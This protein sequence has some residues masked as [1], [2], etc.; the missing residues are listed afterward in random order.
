MTRL[1]ELNAGAARLVIA[2]EMGGG[3]AA[4]DVD[5]KPVL[6]PWSGQESDGYFAL[7]SN[8]LVPF[9]NRISGGGFNW[10][11]HRH[12]VAPNLAGEA[13]PIHG[14]GFQEVWN[15]ESKSSD[16]ASLVLESGAIG[17]W[18]YAARQDFRIDHT[19]LRIDLTITNKGPDILPFGFGFHPWFPRTDETQL[20]FAA[21][22]VWMEDENYLPTEHRSLS[23]TREWAFDHPRR[24]PGHWLNN[25]YSGWQQVAEL[26]QG[27]AF[28][29]VR[30]SASPN[31]T[32]AIVHSVGEGCDFV[33][34]EPVSHSVDAVNRAASEMVELKPGQKTS[35]WMLL[36]W[37]D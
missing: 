27:S 3:I 28:T 31:L 26:R 30:I 12:D 4:L 21:D 13:C 22:G 25:A 6:R 34:F 7:A 2:P 19:S 23:D 18:R 15:V 36:E 1:L 32:H 14:D 8:I 20:S 37:A 29:S 24:L 10:N 11:G 33:C 5:S 9:S 16:S 35:C 17:P